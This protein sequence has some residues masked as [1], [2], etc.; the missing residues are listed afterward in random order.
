VKRSGLFSGSIVALVTP[1]RQGRPDLA[2]IRDLARLHAC[3]GTSALCPCGT[4]GEGATLTR[5]ERRDVIAACK[6]AAGPLKVIAGVGTNS[7]T[8]TIENA[9]SAAAAGADALLV[10]TPY[11]NKPPLAGMRRHFEAVA[12]AVELPIILY[13]VPGRTGVNLEVETVLELSA[14][15]NIVAI[16]EA[17]G[18]LEQI[19]RICAGADL[20]VLSGDD[21]LTW[22]VL[23][24][25]GVGVI[26][27][28]ANI[29]PKEM[30]EL[31]RTADADRGR[32]LHARY[33]KLFKAL[34]IESN[35]VPVKAAMRHLGLIDSD[36]V[37]LPLSTIA[38]ANDRRLREVLRD[39]A[40]V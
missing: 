26:S 19:S 36:E 21:A 9:R 12:G 37:R 29:I 22:P 35:P 23:R 1:L 17:S 24:M 34:F 18:N 8:E 31:C 6:E 28:A 15:P 27:V 7:T 13:N 25:G 40:L 4:T 39:Y 5:E 3:S 2:K 32:E 20:D 16:K 10:V 14:V 38:E 33:Q 30:A 11:Y